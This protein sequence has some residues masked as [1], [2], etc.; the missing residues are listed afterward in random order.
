MTPSAAALVAG[1]VVAVE[2]P[3][4]EGGMAVC[5]GVTTG[6]PTEVG[7]VGVSV[8]GG[9]ACGGTRGGRM[10]D[11]AWETDERDVL[12]GTESRSGETED[13]EGGLM[14]RAGT[15]RPNGCRRQGDADCGEGASGAGG[16]VQ[17]AGEEGHGRDA[18]TS[19]LSVSSA[20]ARTGDVR[21]RHLSLRSTLVRTGLKLCE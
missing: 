12:P 11:R 4:A 3:V 2:P 18:S 5:G 14:T 13:S 8:R 10:G 7:S 17:S 19:E 15:G 21:L 16:C 9:M 6:L 1:A 20:A